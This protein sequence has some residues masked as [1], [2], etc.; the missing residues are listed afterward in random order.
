MVEEA[1]IGTVEPQALSLTVET[2]AGEVGAGGV[3]AGEVGSHTLLR[4]PS[5]GR[6][7]DWFCGYVLN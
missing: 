5:D 3:G 6:C 7:V 1:P 2:Q 4:L